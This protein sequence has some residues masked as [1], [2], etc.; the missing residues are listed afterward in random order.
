MSTNYLRMWST[1]NRTTFRA[2]SYKLMR[3]D[4]KA[5]TNAEL[6]EEREAGGVLELICTCVTRRIAIRLDPTFTGGSRAISKP[7]LSL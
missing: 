7:S 2:I 4:C 6:K 3:P 1:E 5:L